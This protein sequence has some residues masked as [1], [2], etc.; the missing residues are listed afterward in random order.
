MKEMLIE[1]KN[2]NAEE[3]IESLEK[4]KTIKVKR[5]KSADRLKKLPDNYIASQKVLAKDWLKKSEDK[6][7]E[8]L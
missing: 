8:N 6:A 5:V 3:I 4:M 1:I 7:W 2:K